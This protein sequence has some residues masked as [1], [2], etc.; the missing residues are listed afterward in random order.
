MK[1]LFKI[2]IIL[3]PI[4]LISV[5]GYAQPTHNHPGEWKLLDTSNDPVQRHENGAVAVNGKIYLIGGRGD[6]PISVYDPATN[7]WSNKSG[8]GLEM[9]HFQA[10]EYKGKIYVMGAFNGGWG[11][12]VPIP[13][14]WTYDVA[15]DQW[16]E[17]PTIPEGRRR[18]SAGVVVYNDKIYMVSGIINGHFSGHVPWLDE[19]DPNTG[20]WKLLPD[21]PR[22]R[23]HFHAA[24]Y[25]G[26]IYAAAGR[27]SR[28]D[29]IF[30]DTKSEID[31][32]DINAGQWTTLDTTIPTPRAG[33]SAIIYKNELLII[34]GE[35]MS[36]D[37][38][39]AETEVLNLNNYSWA[40]MA[41]MQIGRH[42]TQAVIIGNKIF[43][44]SGSIMRGASETPTTEFFENDATQAADFNA[45]VTDLYFTNGPSDYKVVADGDN[46]DLYDNGIDEL[47]LRPEIQTDEEVGSVVYN[48]NGTDYIMNIHP[49]VFGHYEWQN[50][51]YVITATPYSDKNGE[52]RAG[53]S[54]TRSFTIAGV[55]SL[56]LQRNLINEFNFKAYPNPFN[57]AIN[58]DFT[59]HS[60]DD[61]NLSV[62]DLS[63]A[64]VQVVYA[65][66]GSPG[67]RFNLSFENAG[68]NSGLYIANLRI[69]DKVI[70]QK[71]MFNK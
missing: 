65:G 51:D 41:N 37:E 66:K 18:A 15:A 55:V 68:I 5:S 36:Q 28:E 7:S 60:T 8:A 27:N 9:H 23:D 13:N 32:Y 26:K 61:I 54:L 43:M 63:G 33:N 6:N 64:L 11:N 4:I 19:F 42:G 46:L 1:N 25:D 62:Y 58:I 35:S 21:A 3:I 30:G 10:V 40:K 39:H 49:F 29:N 57:N 47:H 52:G 31:V 59:A 24:V 70:R 16:T 44:P 34:G 12:E 69:G 50:D 38:A 71:I 22:S 67:K 45:Q 17:G 56:N 53:S 20:E 14:V 48:I 2:S